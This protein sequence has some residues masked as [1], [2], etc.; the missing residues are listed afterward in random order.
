MKITEQKRR[1]HALMIAFGL[2]VEMEKIMRRKKM[3]LEEFGTDRK[4]R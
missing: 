2:G 3:T 4:R 1:A